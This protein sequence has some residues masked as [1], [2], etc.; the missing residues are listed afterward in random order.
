[1]LRLLLLACRHPHLRRSSSRTKVHPV[2]GV[3][4]VTGLFIHAGLKTPRF[5]N[6]FGVAASPQPSLWFRFST[7][8]AA[9]R[10]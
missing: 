9:I 8:R 5:S 1:M 6:V 2:P 4:L 7:P 3:I 10:L